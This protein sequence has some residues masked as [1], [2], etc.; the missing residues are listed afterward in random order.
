MS[1]P[2]Y[3]VIDASERAELIAR[4]PENAVTVI[5][6]EPEGDTDRY[7]AAAQRLD[8]WVR[9]GDYAVDEQPALYV[10]EMRDGVAGRRREGWSAH[11]SCA[12]RPTA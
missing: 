8:R 4:D 6:P 12:T 5:L 11:S 2:P 7:Q 1:C 9:E 10:Y 3:D